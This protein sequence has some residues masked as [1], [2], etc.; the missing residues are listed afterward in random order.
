MG[1]QQLIIIGDGE[2]AELAY[3]YFTHDSPYTV[4]GFAVESAYKTKDEFFGLPV[5]DLEEIEAHY[6][7]AEYDAFAAIS[8][9]QLNRVR[10][11]LFNALKAKGYTCA[12]Y[13][14]SRAFVWHNVEIGENCFIFENNV[15]QYKVKIGN[16]VVLWSG[17]HIGHQ[18]VIRDNVFISSHVV[19][20]GYCDVG[21]YSF[22]GVNSS[23]ANDVVIARDNLIAMGAVI[24]KSTEPRKIYKGNPAR[25]D[26]TKDSFAV[27]K[28]TEPSE[29]Q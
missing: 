22:L 27:M 20:S 5:V 29:S 18:S 13:V 24:H 1:A 3:E 2:T 15:I 19:V 9:T 21:E 25:P 14:S 8:Y 4:A 12:S 10:E 11:R 16:N 28:V 26:E 17:N 7:P 23:V 6:P